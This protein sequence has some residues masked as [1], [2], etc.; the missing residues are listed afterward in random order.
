MYPILQLHRWERS[1][2]QESSNSR[3]GMQRSIVDETGFHN[4]LTDYYRF[5]D[6]CESWFCRE[7]FQSVY[8]R[9]IF[10]PKDKYIERTVT[11]KNSWF[12]KEGWWK[13]FFRTAYPISVSILF[14]TRVSY[15]R[16][17]TLNCLQVNFVNI[18]TYRIVSLT[19]V[20]LRHAVILQ[21]I[22]MEFYKLHAWNL[23]F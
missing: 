11:D 7:V 4:G 17:S 10:I 3:E 16:F 19:S 1:N 21:I 13:K 8:R 23:V 20:Q 22:C 6:H 14:A 18:W 2:W 12:T 5:W 9:N 15:C